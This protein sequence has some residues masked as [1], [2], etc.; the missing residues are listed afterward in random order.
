MS[1]KD[2]L[3]EDLPHVYPGLPRPD[4]ERLLTLLDQSASTEAS[5][6]LSV[7]TALDPLVPNVARRIE[8]YKAS[9]DV[10]DYL[11][12]LRG[13][14]VLLLQE[15]QSQGQPPPPDSIVNL[16]DKVERDS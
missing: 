8:S 10:D 2:D 16:V 13:A 9:G 4:V 7:A 5:M 3:L 6:G 11:R 12:M 14:A 15:W 1:V